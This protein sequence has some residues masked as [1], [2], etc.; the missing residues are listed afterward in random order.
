MHVFSEKDQGEIVRVKRGEKLAKRWILL[1][2]IGLVLVGVIIFVTVKLVPRQKS[3]GQ[4]SIISERRDT[5]AL[6]S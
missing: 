4:Y 2:A 6:F 3:P 1:M 5:L